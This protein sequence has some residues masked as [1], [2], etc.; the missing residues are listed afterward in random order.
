MQSLRESTKWGRAKKILK[1]DWQLYSLLLIPILYFI[2]FKYGPMFGNIIAFRRFVPGG[3]IIGEEWVGLYYFQMFLNDPTFFA[4]FQNTLILALLLLVITFPIPIIFAL[5]LNEIKRKGFKRFVQTTSYLPHFFSMVVVAGM[6]LELVSVNGSINNL[7][8]F[9]TGN[10]Y[11]FIQMPEWFR[12]IFIS[13][14]VW[15]TTGW[16]AILYLAALTGINDEL[17][18][19]A[20]IDGANRWKQTLHITIPGILPTIVVL[21]ILNIGNFL[22]VGFEKILLLYNPLIYETA[23]VIATYVYRIGI[24]S[25]SFSYGTAIGLFEA[26]IGLILVFGANFLSRKVTDNSL[27]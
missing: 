14:D 20:R 25:A 17:Y 2:I 19:A 26:L 7:V 18:E 9:F 11:S 22:Q 16:G 15:Q 4:V 10:R 13:S 23:D 27:W 12:T 1:K 8:E 5:L 24:Q 6:V 21:L 3:N